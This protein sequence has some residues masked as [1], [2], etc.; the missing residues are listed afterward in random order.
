MLLFSEPNFF[1]YTELK[2]KSR[3]GKLLIDQ[4]VSRH[5]VLTPRTTTVKFYRP[6]TLAKIRSFTV[7]LC[8]QLLTSPLFPSK[9]YPEAL[10]AILERKGLVL[11]QLSSKAISG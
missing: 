2:R 1:L 8:L 7:Q 9:R 6:K 4:L 11:G 10:I 5:T 3:T